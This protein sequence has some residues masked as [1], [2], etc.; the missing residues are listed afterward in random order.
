[1]WRITGTTLW[2]R[3][4]PSFDFGRYQNLN[5]F[6]LLDSSSMLLGGLIKNIILIKYYI[7]DVN[8]DQLDLCEST[9]TP[10]NGTVC[11]IQ[12]NNLCIRNIKNIK[13]GFSGSLIFSP[14]YL[15]FII[16]GIWN[17]EFC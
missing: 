8:T 7:L 15:K 5:I 9:I 10:F 2:P 1:M 13:I 3:S 6:A 14:I 16:V 11:R 4:S 17:Y 12:N